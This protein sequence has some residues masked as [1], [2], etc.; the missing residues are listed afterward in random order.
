VPEVDRI[1]LRHMTSQA[2]LR[3]AL[4]VALLGVVGI[5]GMATLPSGNAGAQVTPSITTDAGQY[6]SGETVT[7]TGSNWTGCN[8]LNIDLF[9]PS[10]F[11]VATG[12]TPVNG[13]FTGTFTAPEI[14]GH[15]I[16]SA[17]GTDPDSAACSAETI[18]EV[19]SP[20]QTTGPTPLPNPSITTDAAQY[21]P[22]DT[23]TYTGSGFAC[24]D[25][26]IDLF[27]PTGFTV[28]T[29]VTPVNGSFTGTFTAPSIVSS[30]ILFAHNLDIFGC[31]KDTVFAVVAPP[32]TTTT[33]TTTTT[34]ASSTTAA[35]TMTTA[36][37]TT[38]TAGTTTTALAEL[39]ATGSGD[40]PLALLAA[41][42]VVLGATIVVASRVRRLS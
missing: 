29:G 21:L 31:S 30:Y 11:T 34:A 26:D 13:S 7:Y 14:D 35:P 5:G 25:L 41:A 27:G 16:L 37:P 24:D 2:G 1:T 15:Y 6:F 9:G 19:T 12:V 28:A 39:P 10:G 42:I 8:V 40:R 22:G 3:R 17:H 38:T 18:F 20:P 32:P 4:V 36:A 33:T 23:V